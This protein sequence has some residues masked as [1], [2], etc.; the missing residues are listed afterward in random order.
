MSRA[1]APPRDS[2]LLLLH[3]AKSVIYGVGNV[4]SRTL[5]VRGVGVKYVRKGKVGSCAARARLERGRCWKG[6]CYEGERGQENG[7]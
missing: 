6:D 5:C 2:I 3:V 7:K 1:D 4:N